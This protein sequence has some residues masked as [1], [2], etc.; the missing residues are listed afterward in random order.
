[1]MNL[2]IEDE[3]E[4]PIRLSQ[5]TKFGVYISSHFFSETFDTSPV[6]VV[7]GMCLEAQGWMNIRDLAP[8]GRF[9]SMP[10]ASHRNPCEIG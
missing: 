1:M 3:S 9:L 4:K 5:M 2:D 7:E 10:T 6:R 8:L